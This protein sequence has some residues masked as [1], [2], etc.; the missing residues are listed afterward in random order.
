MADLIERLRA[1]T[2]GFDWADLPDDALIPAVPLL[3]EAADSIAS[4][5]TERDDARRQRDEI[6]RA[7]DEADARAKEAEARAASLE[8]ALAPFAALLDDAPW[9]KKPDHADSEALIG[10]VTLGDF[11][12]AAALSSSKQKDGG[13]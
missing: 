13:E 7:W 3:R 8:T 4:L 10:N 12:R 2:M 11:R 5:E 6:G 9:L 1:A